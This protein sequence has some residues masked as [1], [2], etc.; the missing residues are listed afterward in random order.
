MFNSER[1]NR[2]NFGQE[3][4]W[5]N[6]GRKLKNGFRL[7]FIFGVV[8]AI[9]QIVFLTLSIDMQSAFAQMKQII[10]WLSSKVNFLKPSNNEFVLVIDSN[11]FIW[12]IGKS[13]AIAIT[14]TILC[15]ILFT[16][17]GKNAAKEQILD[18]ASEE[19]VKSIN[20]KIY[21]WT[22]K[23]LREEKKRIR[24]RY[25]FFMSCDLGAASKNTLKSF[26]YGRYLVLGDIEHIFITEEILKTHIGIEG[27]TGTGKSVII[28]SILDQ[29]TTHK[30]T[31]VCILDYNG[32]YFS[33]FGRKSDK[34]I[35]INEKRGVKWHP[36]CENIAPE[37]IAHSLIENDPNDKFFGP[38]AKS[39]FANL[40]TLNNK[41]EDFWKDMI[42]SKEELFEKLSKYELSS[43]G[44]FEGSSGNQGAGVRRTMSLSL[45]ALRSLNYWT[46]DKEEFSVIDWAKNGSKD[47]LYIIVREEDLEKAKPWIRL[48]L[49][50]VVSG[51]LMRNDRAENNATWLVADEL[52]I[53]GKLPSLQKGI[54]NGRKYNFRCVIGYQ[55][56]G[57]IDEVYDKEA[58][59]IK[60]SVRTRI[61]FNP[62]DHESAIKCAE[63]LGKKEIYDPLESESYGSSIKDSKTT[64]SSS[65]QIREKFVVHPSRLRQMD[66]ME[67]YMKI[68]MFNPVFIKIPLKEYE[69]IN[70]ANE[71]EEPPRLAV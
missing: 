37:K 56:E 46:K 15:Q 28:S 65:N 13:L 30:K 64:I 29:L 60:N 44:D 9:C 42:R 33:K 32:Q 70:K 17:I 52:P 54:T 63:T 11:I 67:C 4:V 50:L 55:T 39:L 34:I 59:G 20:D 23:W 38:A 12:A 1:K 21:R 19:S 57:Q 31:Q 48:W 2:E 69:T 26:L 8:F 49:D 24:Q 25:D 47:W 62:G 51:I 58:K 7:L 18:G 43:A 5:G 35:S 66:K 10:A 14:F 40:M 16:Y 3:I 41:I 61:I 71:C 22:L 45:D 6:L 68:L 36:W 53:L 27:A